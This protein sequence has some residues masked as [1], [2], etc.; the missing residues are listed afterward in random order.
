MSIIDA[1]HI[2]NHIIERRKTSMNVASISVAISTSS[3]APNF[4][5]IKL[6]ICKKNTEKNTIGNKKYSFKLY[7]KRLNFRNPM[8]SA[9]LGYKATRKAIR[10]IGRA[11]TL[12]RPLGD[13]QHQTQLKTKRN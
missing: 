2:W 6:S 11:G 12:M 1:M 13:L 7:K 3:N 4:S 5:N 8:F 10:I 9:N